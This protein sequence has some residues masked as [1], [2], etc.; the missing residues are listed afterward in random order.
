MSDDGEHRNRFRHALERRIG[1]PAH[2][3]RRR[4]GKR[5]GESGQQGGKTAVTN[6]QFWLDLRP[7]GG[8]RFEILEIVGRTHRFI[9]QLSQIEPSDR[10]A[11][12]QSLIGPEESAVGNLQQ[13]R[14]FVDDLQ[15]E[16]HVQFIAAALLPIAADAAQLAAVE[17][18]L[19]SH[20]GGDAGAAFE[21]GPRVQ[22]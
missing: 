9:A 20:A 21:L 19:V 13:A 15:L 7:T 8:S 5:I 11:G 17:R 4:K 18:H 10:A 16:T 3:L 14:L 6:R 22:Q 1:R 2:R 12:R